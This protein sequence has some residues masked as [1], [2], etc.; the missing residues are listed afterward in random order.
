MA[1]S[2]VGTRCCRAWRPVLTF[3]EGLQPG[4]TGESL[5]THL[6]RRGR[7]LGK[8][9]PTRSLKV[10]H[11]SENGAPPRSKGGWSREAAALL[12]TTLWPVLQRVSG[13]WPSQTVCQQRPCSRTVRWRDAAEAVSPRGSQKESWQGANRRTNTQPPDAPSSPHTPTPPGRRRPREH[14]G[15]H[16][17]HLHNCKSSGSHVN[18]SRGWNKLN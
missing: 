10:G 8:A 13:D 9:L 17:S 3:R 16:G 14:E 6:M 1:R 11:P 12:R 4:R 15:P 7:P 5:T 18:T 2:T